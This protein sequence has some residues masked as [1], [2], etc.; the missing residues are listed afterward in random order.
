MNREQDMMRVSVVIPCFNA[1]S[2]LGD[3]IRSVLGQ[4]YSP[5]EVIVVDDGSRDN[6]AAIAAS[7]GEPI[8]V[9]RQ[10]NQGECAA[11]N[12][13]LDLARG[14]WIAFL[15]ADDLWTPK[16]LECQVAEAGRGPDI[17][18]IHTRFY[19][20]GTTSEVPPP[21]VEVVSGTY[22][23]ETLL[24]NPLVNSSSAMVR[25][26]LPVRFPAGARQ[27][28]DMIYFTELSLFGL[29]AYVPRALTG[30]RMHAAQV[31]RHPN[32]WVEHFQNR[33][34]WVRQHA[35]EL[36]AHRAAGLEDKL[37]GQVLEW[38]NLARW[39]RQWDRYWRLREYAR[40]LNWESQLPEVLSERIY[41]RVLYRLKDAYDS[42]LSES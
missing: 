18:C 10:S 39:N 5:H 23:I 8:R 6:S 41:P 38:L 28:G 35:L 27:G 3:T 11:R 31:T 7:F 40:T 13:G 12:T 15:D 19:Q 16:K 25:A 36:G 14:D 20:F 22:E 24:L 29:F 42:V 17:V 30:Y 37:R 33:F 9:I 26:G 1:E 34:Q 2:F 4:T 21:P 32:A